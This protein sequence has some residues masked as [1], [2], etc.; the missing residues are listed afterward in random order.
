MSKNGDFNGILNILSALRT[1]NPYM[2]ENCLK[3]PSVYTEKEL[4]D[5]LQ[6][7]GMSYDKKK[8]TIDTL[9]DKYSVEYN[10]KKTEDDNFNT[11]SKKIN[12][13]IQVLNNKVSENDIFID[14]KCG[15]T[16]YVM[17]DDTTYTL[18]KGN[19]K[20]KINKPNRNIKP[21]VCINNDI[22]V[23]WEIDNDIN[24]NKKIFGGYIKATL[25]QNVEHWKEMLVNV[26]K[27][28]DAN[29]KKPLQKDENKEI[30]QMGYWI[31]TQQKN[32]NKKDCIMKDETI[33]KQW[34]DFI[35]NAKYKKY[36]L[37]NNAAWINML[38]D[39][40]K[41]I[42]SN[43]RR[44]SQKNEG[45]EI[46]RMGH[47]LSTQQKIYT[48][49]TEIMKNEN[50]RK[51]WEDFINDAKYKEYFLDNNTIWIN[52]L[53]NVKKYIDENEKK[54]SQKSD[55]IEV[56]Q[57]GKWLSDQLL[58]YKKKERIMKNETIY[59]LW[60]D[61]IGD[62]KYKEYFL[63]NDTTWINMLEN[64]KIYINEHNEK[65]SRTDQNNKVKQMAAWLHIQQFN[66]NKKTNIVKD[67]NIC[68][69]WEDFINDVKYKEYFTDNNTAWTN[70]LTNVK[71]Y[72]DENGKKPSQI[73][74][75]NEV[76]QMGKWIQHQQT[77][78][79]KKKNIMKNKYIFDQ[80]EN[81]INNIKYKEHFKILIKNE[82]NN[83]EISDAPESVK[84]LR[85]IEQRDNNEQRKFTDQLKELYENKC[86]I[87]KSS[88]ALEGAHII[89]NCETNKFDICDGLLLKSDVHKMY[90]SYEL[91]INP[92]TLQV[93]M[94]GDIL[95]D[96]YFKQF[97][98]KKIELPEKYK[99]RIKENLRIMYNR[100][101]NK[102]NKKVTR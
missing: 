85:T 74:K 28:I 81:F 62:A 5:N 32:Y 56:R 102:H 80:W 78:Y 55:N 20:D 14:N 75:S 88:K 18:I 82:Q 29:N 3:Y 77:N 54:P 96:D 34:K 23:L 50:I 90:D 22:K 79:I 70:M 58:T 97:N 64:V 33:R 66:Y 59:K 68:K 46:K 76:R 39:V 72:I 10:K 98:G 27:Y 60:E 63:D 36:F 44:P 45:N 67:E 93:E 43:N 2:F 69:Q 31:S 15:E 21:F 16:I 9:F 52:M 11:L 26:K 89:P 100:F 61:F 53:E 101:C 38:T 42:D 83:E 8:Y 12:K 99:D 35:D 47:W 6:K 51:L 30:M 73:D 41:Y 7:Y 86:V 94:C 57:M 92:D 40:K 49:K 91:T 24:L 48:K 95:D 65:P 25:K 84:I 87:T 37:D 17:K 4:N 1:E 13:N 19:H 71:K